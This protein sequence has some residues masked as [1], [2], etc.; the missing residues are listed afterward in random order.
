MCV[1][2]NREQFWKWN[3]HEKHAAAADLSQRCGQTVL[4]D[5]VL[6]AGRGRPERMQSSP[7][8]VPVSCLVV[9]IPPSTY[10]LHGVHRQFDEND[11]NNEQT[12][13][14]ATYQ[15][16]AYLSIYTVH[17]R[18]SA[19]ERAGDGSTALAQPRQTPTGPV[20]GCSTLTYRTGVLIGVSIVI[21][22]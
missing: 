14:D 13:P 19:S 11:L 5:A 18:L 10:I 12:R 17:R 4:H 20:A 2:C 16:T 22:G 21:G 8:S 15:R 9:D 7:P 3:V 1:V 6:A